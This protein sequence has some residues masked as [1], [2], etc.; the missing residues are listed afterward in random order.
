MTTIIEVKEPPTVRGQRPHLL[1]SEL[2]RGRSKSRGSSKGILTKTW[3]LSDPWPKAGLKHP[4][5]QIYRFVQ[6]TE[7]QAWVTTST[8]AAVFTTYAPVLSGV[9]L[10]SSLTA[11]FDQYRIPTI[12]VWY[13]PR[14]AYGTGPTVNYGM[15]TTVVDYDD[16]SAL[17]ST[18]QAL[19]YSNACTTSGNQGHYRK[20]T[21]HVAV[22]AY[23][24]VF[25]SFANETAPWI[26]VA[27]SSV[28]HFGWK[29]A[30][31]ATDQAY[32]WDLVTRYVIEFRNVR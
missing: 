17:T 19:A 27:S 8:V 13:V 21:P 32:V 30:H 12:E 20:F 10:A 7:N 22:A 14:T 25:T 9:P 3:S 24:G 15:V 11:V 4:D 23:S 31:T 18:T 26:D 28:I 5:N 6:E 1:Q 29:A 2:G 16:S